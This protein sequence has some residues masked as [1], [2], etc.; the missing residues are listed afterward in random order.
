LKSTVNQSKV[1]HIMTTD[2]PK[3]T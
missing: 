1:E 3:K 2:M